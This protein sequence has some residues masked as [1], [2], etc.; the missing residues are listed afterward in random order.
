[1]TRRRRPR[2]LHGTY[3]Q[4]S[5]CID[6]RSPPPQVIIEDPSVIGGVVQSTD[7]VGTGYRG[8]GGRPPVPSPPL[9]AAI[10]TWLRVQ[11]D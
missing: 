8:A 11:L 5:A 9:R 6:Y 4:P 2:P 10:D 7:V 3:L 1:M